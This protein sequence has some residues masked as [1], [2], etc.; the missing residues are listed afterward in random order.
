MSILSKHHNKTLLIGILL[1]GLALTGCSKGGATKDASADKTANS[2][3]L[4]KDKKEKPAVP[5]EVTS[6]TRGDIQQTYRTI[7]TLQAEQEAQVVARTSGILEML[8]VEEGDMVKKG[9]ILAQLDVEQLTL[10]LEQLKAGLQKLE[11][12]LKRQNSLFKR[13]LGSN[14]SLEKVR[15]DHQAQLAQY[16]L[17]KLK[18]NYA[19]IKAPIS[20][21][22]TER[23][24]KSG[25]MI[26]DNDFLFKIVN[27]QS[28]KAI[29]HL[30]ERE[31]SNIKKGQ[32]ILLQVDAFSDQVI[33]GNIERI[34]PLID[35]D[36]GTFKVVAKLDNSKNILHAGMFGK[37]EVVFEV[38]TDS[39]L[40]E[41]QALVTQDNR[42]HVFVVREN[43][44]IQTPIEIG[45]KHNGV[46]EITSGL[47]ENDRVIT[48][49]QQILK[50]ENKVEIIGDETAEQLAEK[51]KLKE[52]SSATTATSKIAANP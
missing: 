49:G 33:S 52:S 9:Q 3:V 18:L 12:E 38:H 46:V 34:R 28:L 2:E 21:V 1:T 6:V 50:H 40:L 47:Q 23:M 43:K 48:T 14:D 25:N 4:E 27:P 7:T 45:F 31:L 19:S 39:L 36:T 37:V 17:A 5:V 16:K 8:H 41:Q 35:S 11:G 32:K 51:D 42:S 29:L 15:F 26:R 44:A 22:I 13:K 10:E 20:G 24:V 30:P